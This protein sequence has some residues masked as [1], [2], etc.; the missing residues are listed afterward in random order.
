MSDLL[1]LEEYKAIAAELNPSLR[2]NRCNPFD[3]AL[4]TGMVGDHNITYLEACQASADADHKRIRQKVRGHTG[5]PH[6][7]NA[8][9]QTH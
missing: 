5:T 9:G 7:V 4:V 6:F 1:T 8:N 2:I 3:D